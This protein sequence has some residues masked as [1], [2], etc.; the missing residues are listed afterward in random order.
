[1]ATLK[2]LKR[3]IQSVKSTQKIT[4]AMMMI[5]SA[6]LR[7]AQR[8]IQ[9][10]YP[11][12]QK[13]SQLLNIF[14]SSEQEI[15]TPFAQQRTVK[16]VAI[17]AFSSNNSL[18]GRFND[19]V[20]D[21]LRDTLKKYRA[22]GRE[23]ILVYAIGDKAAKAS[24]QLGYKSQR[25][26]SEIS[27]TPTYD[28]AQKLA[29]ELM[30]MFLHQKVDRVEL[31][32]HHF[33]TKSSQVIRHETFLP[34]EL[35]AQKPAGKQLDYIVEPDKET[36]MN[37]LIPKVLKLKIYTIHAD[38]VTSEHAARMVAMQI[39][40]DN[41]DNLIDELTLQFNKLRQQTITNELLDIIGGSFG[42]VSG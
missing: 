36:V 39:A 30:D 28:E 10:L 9:N 22:L 40:T 42:R 13:L 37:Q 4:S 35:Q 20:T 33:R 12:E 5:S 15:T 2:E 24:L 32:Y 1:M 14:L 26:F 38:S 25:S 7:K 27:E 16:R 11:Y 23:N 3:R 41:A 18:V 17:V 31:I 34:I 21:E 29:G 6:K 8:V 19:N